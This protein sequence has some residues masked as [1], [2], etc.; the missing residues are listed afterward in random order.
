[1]NWPTQRLIASAMQNAM[2]VMQNVPASELDLT[3][4]NFETTPGKVPLNTPRLR[5]SPF[6]TAIMER[7]RR[8]E[9][10]I[11][12]AMME[13]YLAGVSV[14]RVED[15]TEAPWGAGVSAGTISN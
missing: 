14:R 7:Y 8:R 15:I 5:N 13:I 2:D 10:S 6:E 9:S 3:R 12:E 4:E 1:M 11:E